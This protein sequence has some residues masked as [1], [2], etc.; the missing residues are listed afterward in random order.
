MLRSFSNLTSVHLESNI[1]SILLE[2]RAIDVIR[3]G[4]KRE[5]MPINDLISKCTPLLRKIPKVLSG[6]SIHSWRFAS[7]VSGTSD[8][9]SHFQRRSD[10]HG[11]RYTYYY[12]QLHV[13]CAPNR[14]IIPNYSPYFNLTRGRL[15]IPIKERMKSH[16][17]FSEWNSIEKRKSSRRC[18]SEITIACLIRSP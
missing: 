13:I 18:W 17:Y 5:I 11:N 1:K 10:L 14:I 3:S 9:S 2:Y 6:G 8:S 4:P 16:Y 7:N 12:T 15:N